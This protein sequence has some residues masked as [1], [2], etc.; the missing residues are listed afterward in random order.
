[1]K[2]FDVGNMTCAACS[3][4]VEKTVSSLD[5]VEFCSVNLLTNSMQVD[6]I[7]TNEEIISAVEKIG[8]TASLKGEKQPVKDKA[9][10]GNKSKIKNLFWSLGFV[11]ILMYVSMGHSMWGWYLPEFL[12]QN[13]MSLG[14][15][16]FI[17]SAIVLVINQRFFISGFKAVKNKAPNMDTLVSLGSG[18]SFFYSTIVLFEISFY[19]LN[20]NTEAAF[21]SLH[22]LYFESA[23]MILA[24]ISLGKILEEY[25]KG[26]TTN[27]LNSLIDLSPKK[28]SIITEDGEKIVDASSLK[29]GDIIAVRPGESFAADGIIIEGESSVD[30]SI[31]TGE[32]IPLDKKTGDTVSCAT[33]NKSGFLKCEVTNAGEDTL[34]ASIIKTVRDSTA[35]KAPIA[36]IADKVSGVFVPAV[37]LISLITL[38]IWLILDRDFSFAI[39]RAISVLVISCPC[40]LGLATPVAIM[41][42]GGI[43]AK[44]GILFK[45]A[46]SLENLGKINTLVLDKTG[47]V[48]KGKPQVTD[49]ILCDAKSE[50]ELLSAAY[51][52]EIKSG[53]PLSLAI[54]DEAKK[55]NIKLFETEAFTLYEGN[56]VSARYEN[57]II[58]GGKSEFIEEKC[59][60]LSDDI[61]N[62]ITLVAKSGKTPM[63]FAE[64]NKILGIIAVADAPKDDAKDAIERLHSLGIKTVMLTGDNEHTADYIAKKTG[65]QY[66]IAKCLPNM[67]A[68]EI[69]KL[70]KS[71]IV[72][73][74]GD[75]IND[76][77][78][79]TA[80]N[81][82]IAVCKGTDIAIES[83]DV[84]LMK[85]SLLDIPAAIV[86]SRLCLKN[87][88]QNLFWAFI[89]NSLG[90]PLAAG[91]F[92]GILGWQLTPMFGAAAM[93]LSSFCVVSNALRLNL[94]N[95]Y[96]VNIKHKNK[97][98]KEIM[99]KIIKIEGMMCPH[100]EARVKQL[101]EE[102]D[103]VEE[104]ITS[105]KEG[106]AKLI[107]TKDTA[108]EVF[109][110]VITDAGYSIVS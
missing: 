13:P 108:D 100:C 62:K 65:I 30:E 29:K 53:H 87:I 105:H 89:Y 90:I 46:T 64:E 2:N 28:A 58:Y 95:I 77:P 110:K 76:A 83:A 45:N 23:A 101:L 34:L 56:G 9:E 107:L 54:I 98:E 70:K 40:A 21:H 8:Y 67:K 68:K 25:S 82:G 42:S 31:L 12:S 72:A 102:I 17:L 27:A 5:G 91:A 104:A 94:A 52:I 33:V 3:A 18:A 106:T 93:S 63:I 86:L 66:V 16:Q 88:K 99:E 26:K 7:A 48:T 103:G 59:K 78:A 38:A 57:N 69:E 47:T 84:V 92:I 97:K 49:I 71:G 61:K 80:A 79:L 81:T 85:D 75:G 73:M 10:K 15:M 1:M 96:K 20:V 22:N 37:L 44:N 11:I 41:V 19:N 74:V 55:R 14:L 60:K 32:S 6:G 43:G 51:S 36:R 50:N 4:R 109:E 24:L 39:S 35:T